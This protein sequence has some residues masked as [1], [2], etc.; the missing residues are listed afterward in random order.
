MPG[1][2]SNRDELLFQSFHFRVCLDQRL[3][4]RDFGCLNDAKEDKRDHGPI[5]PVNA[6]AVQAV[7]E[8]YGVL[9]VD[10]HLASGVR[11]EAT[12]EL[13]GNEE[14][15]ARGQGLALVA[16]PRPLQVDLPS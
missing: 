8:L 9:C 15:D 12:H 10:K 2:V 13:P 11:H 1:L 16:P 5:L 14:A 3:C 6:L 7:L 4:S